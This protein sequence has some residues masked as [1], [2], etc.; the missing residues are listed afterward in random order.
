MRPRRAAP[1][2]PTPLIRAF[3]QN[4]A[5]SCICHTS[6]KSPVTPTIA[7]D[8]TMR[9]RKPCVCHTCYPLPP[10]SISSP[11]P[12]PSLVTSHSPLPSS[13][14]RGCKF[15]PLF[16]SSCRMLPPQPF[17]FHV[18]AWFP[19]V[20]VGGGQGSYKN[21]F[22]VPL[23]WCSASHE[24]VRG[25]SSLFHESPV[26]SSPVTAVAEI[27]GCIC[28]ELSTVTRRTVR[29][30]RGRP[31]PRRAPAGPCESIFPVRSAPSSNRSASGR[32]FPNDSDSRH[33]Q[34]RPSRHLPAAARPKSKRRS[35]SKPSQGCRQSSAGS[36]NRAAPFPP[37][38]APR[39]RCRHV[40][41]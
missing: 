19:G 3:L 27:P 28:L 8:P 6:E 18:L 7:T 5:N 1:L 20:G 40:R 12:L 22:K 26:T 41:A 2:T 24:V 16:S 14:A 31:F 34:A 23:P 33:W 38:S 11:S 30:K 10:P 25:D 32:P 17:S 21:P 29:L 9:P 13:L 39:S 35:G 4:V 15:A 36:E 37:A